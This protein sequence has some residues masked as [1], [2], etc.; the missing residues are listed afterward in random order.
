MLTEVKNQFKVTRLSIKYAVMRELLNKVT[1][2]SNVIFM[3][4]NNA[5]ML[6]QWIVLYSIKDN[7]GG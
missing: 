3:M 7:M 4:L 6:V 1:F 5:S 2:L